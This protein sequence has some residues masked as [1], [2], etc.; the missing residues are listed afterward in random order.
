MYDE[1]VAKV[2]KTVG[3]GPVW[4]VVTVTT[5][6]RVRKLKMVRVDEQ[7]TAWKLVEVAS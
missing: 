4:V 7:L 5:L 2:S 6:G 3:V 1:T